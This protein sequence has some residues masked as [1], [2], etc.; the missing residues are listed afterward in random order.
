MIRLT[1][2]REDLIRKKFQKYKHKPDQA[3]AICSLLDEIDGLRADL[4]WR[5]EPHV[6]SFCVDCEKLGA[7]LIKE[8]DD[9]KHNYEEACASRDKLAAE[10]ALARERLGPA[11][12]KMLEEL[13]ELRAEK[14]KTPN[15]L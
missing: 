15:S 13:R 1:K 6:A 8:R 11:G 7:K 5:S 2:E 4:L 12:W 14:L 10:V 3:D 9:W